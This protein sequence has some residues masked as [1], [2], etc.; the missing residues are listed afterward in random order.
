MRSDLLSKKE[1]KTLFIIRNSVKHGGKTPSVRDIMRAIDY[2]SPNSVALIIDKLVEKKF[3]KRNSLGKIQLS[4]EFEESSIHGETIEVPLVGMAACGLPMFAEENIE[5]MIPVSIELAKPPHKY[6]LLR[7]V[8]NSMNKTGINDGNLVLV[9]Q[10]QTAST[11]DKV[12]ALIDNEAT[13]KKMVVSDEAII[14]EPCSTD[15]NYKP[16]I[17]TKDFKIQ[18]VVVTTIPNL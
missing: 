3:L 5:A 12:V 8:G 9:R 18:G 2:R 15:K 14:L 13:I 7:A 6:F 16:I 11:G 17:L 10:Q 4:K 1:I